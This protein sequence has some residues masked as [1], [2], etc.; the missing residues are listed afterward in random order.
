MT[1]LDTE[2]HK[3]RLDTLTGLRFYAAFAV[4]LN[5]SVLVIFPAPILLQLAAI[6]PIGVGFFFVLSGFI[7]AWTWSGGSTR[8]FYGRRFA[9]IYP[10]HIVTTV[11]AIAMLL[12]IGTNV[13]WFTTGL[14]VV[15]LQAWGGEQ[16]GGGNGPSWSL[17]VEMFFYILFPFIVGPIRKL[18]TRRALSL[19]GVVFAAMFVWIGAYAVANLRID[20][21]FVEAFSPYTNPVYRLGEFVIGITIAT[22]MRNGWRLR[23]S[24]KTVG[25]IGI[26][27][28]VLLAGINWVVAESGI[29]LG[30]MPG[31]PYSVQDFMFLP[32]TCFLI[33]GAAA[34]DIRRERTGLNGRRHVKLGE[35]SFALYLVQMIVIIPIAEFWHYDE[36]TLPGLVA[37][38]AVLVISQLAAAALFTW[39]EKP[40]ERFL[41]P[42]IGAE[43]KRVESHV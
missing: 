18:A 12:I 1:S 30:S 33:A 20:S 28:Y 38:V 13:D 24:F 23:W 32:F 39:L 3:A 11:L 27:G 19:A 26:A 29:S 43:R 31:L 9:R 34:A 14:S 10:L 21:A 17:S 6:G 42:R 4:I 41:R 35:W 15:L 5:H 25:A 36:A 8:A 2:P 16:W 7:L 22:A 40:V 37:L